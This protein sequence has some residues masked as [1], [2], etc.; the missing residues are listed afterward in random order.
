M[1][2]WSGITGRVGIRTKIYQFV[3]FGR[4]VLSYG[5][6]TAARRSSKY[7]QDH[8][9]LTTKEVLASVS[10]N[11]KKRQASEFY[12]HSIRISILVQLKNQDTKS[13]EAMVHSIQNQTY[14]GWELY[15]IDT[16]KESDRRLFRICRN[17]ARSDPRI[18]YYNLGHIL[19]SC[20]RGRT[21]LHYAKGDYYLTINQNT[22]LHPSAFYYMVKTILKEQAD[23]VYSDEAEYIKE[24]GTI[25]SEKYKPDFAPD[26][27][28]GTP[29][30]G[31]MLIFSKLLVKNCGEEIY[32]AIGSGN[33]YELILCLSEKAQWIRHIPRCLYFQQNK[34]KDNNQSPND[35]QAKA[36]LSD[37]LK[38][39]GLKGTVT[40]SY[41]DNTYRI[42]YEIRGNPM[43]SILILNKDCEAHLRKCI[44]SIL[45]KT[46]WNNYEIII[47]ENGSVKEE[48]F[49]LYRELEKSERISII[50]WEK[51]FNFSE[52]NNYAAKTAHGEY[53]LLLNNDTE[54]ITPDWLQEMLMFAQRNDVG[55]AG[56][57][58]YYPDGRI[59]HAGIGVGLM[60]SSG[61]FHRNEERESAGYL[62]RLAYA[63]D[64]SAVTGACMMV[65]RYVYEKAGGL[66]DSFPLVFNDVDFCMRLRKMGY[67]IV[68]TPFAELLHDESTTRGEDSETLEQ[69]LFFQRESKR[70]QIRWQKELTE[71]DPY[72]NPNLS[73]YREDF[74]TVSR[75]FE[76]ETFDL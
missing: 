40:N 36:A 43:V 44:T 27:L 29:Y 37:H 75:A 50:R 53:L 31:R 30:I 12:T 34:G 68:W 3:S 70:F 14:S 28:R 73:L 58:L 67:L 20:D 47:M 35:E 72:Y 60:H 64:L 10:R 41:A 71:G 7:T 76:E 52:M 19:D 38:R 49:K 32:A 63:Q 17:F 33:E 2:K 62:N 59:Q 56:A 13:L 57:K 55:A 69:L 46:T 42:Q 51:P 74:T 15:L 9:V 22:L 11:E 18:R 8:K 1:K 26:S 65:S 5:M 24:S 23:L 66:D 21:I 48:T 39:I 6:K 25:V 16:S 4:D 54:V 45:T 61:H